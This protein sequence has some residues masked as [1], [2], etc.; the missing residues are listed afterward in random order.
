VAG[1]VASEMT[2]FSGEDKS[3]CSGITVQK[4]KGKRK[5]EIPWSIECKT[6]AE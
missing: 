4:A 2:G 6:C 1:A 5:K 3:S